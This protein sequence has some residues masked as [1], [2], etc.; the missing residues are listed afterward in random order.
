MVE[1]RQITEWVSR[2]MPVVLVA[3]LWG[4]LWKMWPDQQ[5]Y[6]WRPE[7][8]PFRVRFVSTAEALQLVDDPTIFAFESKASYRGVGAENPELLKMSES[9]QVRR[10]FLPMNGRGPM[11]GAGGAASDY[12]VWQRRQRGFEDAW[13]DGKAFGTRDPGKQFV[14]EISDNLRAAGYAVEP[15]VPADFESIMPG[16]EVQVLVDVDESGVPAHVLVEKGSGNRDIDTMICRKV[17]LGR[18][19]KTETR[20][21]RIK[22]SYGSE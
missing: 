10:E 22:I 14:M 1:R 15:F 8:K 20:G 7:K 4:G 18:S 19:Q 2:S 6:A 5:F 17:L 16:W 21:G 3:L 9:S 11:A 12:S 13:A